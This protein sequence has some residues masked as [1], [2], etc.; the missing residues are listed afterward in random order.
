MK[1]RGWRFRRS[2]PDQQVRGPARGASDGAFGPAIPLADS[3]PRRLVRVTAT[4]GEPQERARLAELGLTPGATLR[5][6]TRI[7]GGAVIEVLG[8]R[9]CLDARTAREIMVRPLD[10]PP[11][12]CER[13]PICVAKD[14]A[15]KPTKRGGGDGG[16]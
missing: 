13:E 7:N 5:V 2:G 9:L 11:C 4:T 8:S 1:G 12:H 15:G 3:G 14:P 16:Q 6:C 10:A